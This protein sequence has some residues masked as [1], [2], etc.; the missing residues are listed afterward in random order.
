MLDLVDGYVIP[1]ERKPLKPKILFQ[2]VTI[3]EQQKLMDKKMKEMLK[4]G[5]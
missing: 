4:R 2:L 3:R 5:G 1:F